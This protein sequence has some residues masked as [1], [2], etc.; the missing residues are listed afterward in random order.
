MS[1]HFSQYWW[2]FLLRGIFAILLGII[3][4]W[5]PAGT[6]TTLVIFLGAYMFIDGIF[7]VVAA[8]SNRKI[9]DSWVWMLVI[10]IIS[11]IVG[12]ITFR[13]PFVTGAALIYLVAFWA[14]VI[15][16]LEIVVAFSLRK[17]IRGEGWYIVAGILSILFGILL[18]SNPIAGALTITFIF[19]FYAL[20]F[21]IFLVSFAMRL[22]RRHKESNTKHYPSAHT[23]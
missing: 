13:N 17:V 5:A 6:F 18:L 16:I 11:I 2:I 15:G 14:I 7:S 4:L 19:G 3:A 21:G 12:I 1:L 9:M 23:R 10:G 20:I 22:R 8:I